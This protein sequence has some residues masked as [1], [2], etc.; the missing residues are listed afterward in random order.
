MN[1]I[2]YASALVTGKRQITIPKEVCEYYN[3]KI[4]DRVVFREKDGVIVFEPDNV[5]NQCKYEIDKTFRYNFIIPFDMISDMLALGQLYHVEEVFRF[6]E[7]IITNGGK[8]II[9]REYVNAPPQ[10][11]RVIDILDDLKK[12][13]KDFLSTSK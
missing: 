9:Q 13:Q 2:L 6:G 11:M 7:E 10:V 5:V 4:G 3:I 1:G 12:V 8:V